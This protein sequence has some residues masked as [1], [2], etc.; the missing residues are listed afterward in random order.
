MEN[1]KIAFIQTGGTID[2]AY[3]K[4]R[5]SYSFEIDKPAF[6]RVL[7]RV[8]LNLDTEYYSVLKMDSM[9]MTVS[10]REL[11]R[12][13]CIEIDSDKIIIT[14]GS[15]AMVE[16]ASVLSTINNKTIVMVGSMIPECVKGSDAD[17]N[18]GLAVG[19][20]SL[21]PNGVYISM[22]GRIYDWDNCEK[23]DDSKFV[24]KGK[25]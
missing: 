21:M 13:K 4:K 20:V 7:K 25:K 24:E 5:G 8:D 6:Q 3:P 22:S 16:T 11:I 12:D 17:F 9:D 23:N 18:L 1:M 10:D 2:K 19:A 14:H 15:D